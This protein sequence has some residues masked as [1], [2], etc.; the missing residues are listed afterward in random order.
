[1]ELDHVI[2][3]VAG[4]ESVAPLFPGFVLDPGIRH[5]GQGTCNRRVFFPRNYVEI[6]WIEDSEARRRSGLGGAARWAPGAP[7]PFGVVLRGIVGEHDRERY[8]PYQVPAGGPALL[9]LGSA[10]LD[11]RQPFVAVR[12]DGGA[13]RRPDIPQHPSGARGIRRAL[14][15]SPTIPDV[16]TA[17]PR[18]V[19]FE[20]GRAR[21]RLEWDGPVAPWEHPDRNDCCS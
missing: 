10:L 21:L 6:V 7:C 8:E 18:D 16:G 5:V 2:V 3:F 11:P 1:M 13:P 4:P 20:L 17:S 15:R 9:L 19:R 14:L 12:E